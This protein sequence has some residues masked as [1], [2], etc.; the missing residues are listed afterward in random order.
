LRNFILFFY[1]NELGIFDWYLANG[2]NGVDTVGRQTGGFGGFFLGDYYT[3]IL[4]T[5]FLLYR[6]WEIRIVQACSFFFSRA[7]SGEALDL[8]FFFSFK[9]T[10]SV[11]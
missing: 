3:A 5:T 10:Q 9:N 11:L 1:L 4:F 2:E 6:L 8:V 7:C